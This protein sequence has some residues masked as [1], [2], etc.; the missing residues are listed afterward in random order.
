M[1]KIIQ[2]IVFFCLIILICGCEK[3]ESE[4][5]SLEEVMTEKFKDTKYKC[6]GEAN[7]VEDSFNQMKL[8]IKENNLEEYILKEMVYLYTGNI[9]TANFIFVYSFEGTA[10]VMALKDYMVSHTLS[11]A[12]SQPNSNKYAVYDQYVYITQDVEMLDEE[13]YRV[14]PL[15]FEEGG[16][17]QKQII[18]PSK[19]YGNTLNE[20][21][22]EEE[23]F[24]ETIDSYT[25]YKEFIEVFNVFDEQA[26]GLFSTY[27]KEE[28]V[29]QT[30]KTYLNDKITEEDF[31]RYNL[32]FVQN[33]A[34][35][36]SFSGS[37][38]TEYEYCSQEFCYV[39]GMLE[40]RHL[41]RTHL[42]DDVLTDVI[43]Y[44]FY[45]IDKAIEFH[46]MEYSYYNW[47][48]GLDWLNSLYSSHD[49]WR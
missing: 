35:K 18:E 30:A 24:V 6:M 13:F 37:L 7:R 20:R 33:D 5:R 2:S 4:P 49:A 8:Y 34:V 11:Y 29:V 12:K 45:F 10:D 38:K 25:K 21:F 40:I 17:L 31:A 41:V 28:K 46:K 3:I 42:S 23:I 32:L 26:G 27:E 39:N 36:Y 19:A 22:K 43:G 9:N 44:G 47:C 14:L 15:S 16:V 1:K 48:N